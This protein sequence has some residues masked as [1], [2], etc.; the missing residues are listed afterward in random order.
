MATSEA[1]SIGWRTP[2]L[3]TAVPSEIREVTEATAASATKGDTVDP[4]WSGHTSEANPA[5]ST[6]AASANH[7]SADSGCAWR[8]NSMLKEPIRPSSHPR[9]C[10]A[11]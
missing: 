11:R 8:A 4:G 5:R 1:T 3:R 9:L 6:S 10:L 7:C 2:Q